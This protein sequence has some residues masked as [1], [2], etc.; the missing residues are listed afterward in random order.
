MSGASGKGIQMSEVSVEVGQRSCC[1]LCG[2]SAENIT[3][4]AREMMF[5]TREIFS[6]RECRSCGC[7]QLIDDVSDWSQHYPA[8][9]YSLAPRSRGRFRQLKRWLKY[10]K[11]RQVLAGRPSLAGY[12]GSVLGR[13]RSVT[14]DIWL[15]EAFRRELRF[16]SRI[17]DVGCGSGKTLLALQTHGFSR[18]FGVDPFIAEDIRDG[19]GL[20]IRRGRLGEL[21]GSYDFVMFHHSFEH[22][23]DQEML[24]RSAVERLTEGGTILVR[25][26]VIGALWER[27]GV[28]WVQ[29]DPPRHLF[30]HTKASFL[31]LAERCGLQACGV[32]DDGGAFGFW[33]SEQYARDI[34]LMSPK[35]YFIDP[36][37]SIF[38]ADAIAKFELEAQ[39]LN[40]GGRGDQTCF[41]LSGRSIG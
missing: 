36:Q 33:G 40:A 8:E 29:L 31:A 5:G 18:L 9:Y 21:D 30:L 38:G 10:A 27:Y 3:H 6:Y 19:S 2:N 25:I 28:N 16:D 41:F 35:S 32:I 26:P 39:A 22:I 12:L 20:C 13:G 11:A 7:V 15:R 14:D 4:R 1:S 23:A 37:H 17:L 34:P 24:L